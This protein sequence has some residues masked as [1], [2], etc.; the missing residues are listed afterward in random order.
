[1][2]K[3]ATKGKAEPKRK[4]SPTA[5]PIDRKIDGLEAYIETGKYSLAAKRT[6]IPWRTIYDW[7][8]D[9]KN[10]ETVNEIQHAHARAIRRRFAGGAG[11]FADDIAAMRRRIRRRMKQGDMNASEEAQALRA[12]ASSAVD[13]FHAGEISEPAGVTLTLPSHFTVTEERDADP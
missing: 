13:V 4:R 11:A 10:A 7:V 9:P 12:L 6:G 3:R 1:M 2:T 8:R 5:H